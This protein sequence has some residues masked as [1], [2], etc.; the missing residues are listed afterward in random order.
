[1]ALQM[2]A[3]D[4]IEWLRKKQQKKEKICFTCGAEG[5]RKKIV[6]NKVTYHIC[7]ECHYNYRKGF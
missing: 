5:A 7:D 1:M 6:E 4:R 3:K 2:E